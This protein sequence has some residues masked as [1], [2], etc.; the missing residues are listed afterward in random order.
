MD[1]DYTT[2][3]SIDTTRRIIPRGAGRGGRRRELSSLSFSP[4]GRRRL[5]PPLLLLPLLLLGWCCPVAWAQV[6]ELR[7]LTPLYA[8]PGGEYKST[9]VCWYE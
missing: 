4:R 6:Q 1:R 5:P 9:A 7:I 3:S 2:S 8:R